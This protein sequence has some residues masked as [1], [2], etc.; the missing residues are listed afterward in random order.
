MLLDQ[1]SANIYYNFC[2]ETVI[3]KVDRSF[4]YCGAESTL[5][6]MTIYTRGKINI[7]KKYEAHE[8]AGEY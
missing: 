4:I 3:F 5:K 1:V 6:V 2:I 7:P 8:V